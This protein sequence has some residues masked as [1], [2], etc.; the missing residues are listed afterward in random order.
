MTQKY[1]FKKLGTSSKTR[2]KSWRLYLRLRNKI[3][4]GLKSPVYYYEHILKAHVD[5]NLKWLDLGCGH[6]ILPKW[7]PSAQKK[8][9]LLVESSKI[10]VGIDYD[11]LSLKK[12]KHI[13]YLVVGDIHN[14]PFK[15][16][17]FDL[18]SANCVVEHI[19]NP[20]KACLE[21]KTILT[22]N[23]KFIFFTPNLCNYKIFMAASLP[24]KLKNFL[25]FILEQRQL[26]E[27][28]PTYYRMN[29]K[30]YIHNIAKMTNLKINLLTF[31]NG[32]A[33]TSILGPLVI[34]ELLI[35]RILNLKLFAYLRS[36]I[37]C[38]LEKK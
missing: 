24:E 33:S 23:G 19:Q 12:H 26:Q 27:I 30:Y 18:V 34:I 9:A 11:I 31:K 8:Q 16:D 4:P 35:I 20:I 13:K 32:N 6:Q 2:E 14:L 5:T 7:M 28:Y 37:I 25:T 17:I 3:V 21:I 29:T 38:V 1:S 36:N 15:K 10:I 22:T